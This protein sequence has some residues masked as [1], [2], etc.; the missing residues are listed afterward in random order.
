M[1]FM[2]HH[3]VFG[4]EGLEQLITAYDKAGG[5]TWPRMKAH[6]IELNAVFLM[7]IAEFAMESGEPAYEKMALKELGIEA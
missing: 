2:G 7:F 1:D 5:K 4:D 6:I 3:L